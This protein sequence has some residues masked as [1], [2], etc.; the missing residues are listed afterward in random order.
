MRRKGHGAATTAEGVEKQFSL[1]I[2]SFK[3]RKA[4]FIIY[5]SLTLTRDFEPYLIQTVD[6]QTLLGV[7]QRETSDTLFLLSATRIAKPIPRSPIV[8]IQLGPVSTHAT[9]AGSDH[10]GG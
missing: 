7:I 8:T 9:R 5:P 1:I 6:G 2:T 10:D 3:K 4:G